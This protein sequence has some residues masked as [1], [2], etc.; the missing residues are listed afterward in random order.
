M[1]FCVN[2]TPTKRG[3]PVHHYLTNTFKCIQLIKF[4]KQVYHIQHFLIGQQL[5]IPLLL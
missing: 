1:E 3:I 4:I 2:R 5:R